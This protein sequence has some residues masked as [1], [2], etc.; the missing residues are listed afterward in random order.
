M[1]PRYYAPRLSAG[2]FDLPA[3]EL[4]HLRGVRRVGAGQEIEV[5]DG[6]G[7]LAQC[8]IVR[9]E[10]RSVELEPLRMW[11]ED[12]PASRLTI[13]TAIPKG[14]RMLTLVEKVTELGAW[15]VRPLL[16]EFSVVTGEGQARRGS[17]RQRSVEASKQCGRAWLPEIS[18]PVGLADLLAEFSAGAGGGGGDGEGGGG[19]LV[20]LDPSAEGVTFGQLLGGLRS[21]R[22][23]GGARLTA[24]VG[25]EGGF[26]ADEL[27]A[28]LAAGAERVRLGPHVLRVE[29]AA[30]A[31]ASVWS[32]EMLSG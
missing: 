26:S 11:Q 24:L 29:T 22:G 30:I 10:R 27:A 31:V 7:G 16:T 6:A 19:R 2:D 8:R 14:D 13:A 5:F 23:D 32:A 12:A 28:A 18:N 21:Q 17:W 15:A 3:E 9:L 25:P 4:H 20:L 1:A